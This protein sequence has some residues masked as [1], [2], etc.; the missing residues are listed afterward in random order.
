MYLD[1]EPFD[2]N[3]LRLTN[4]MDAHDSLFFHGRIPPRVLKE[5]DCTKKVGRICKINVPV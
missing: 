5:K 2:R 3:A 1:N 4:S